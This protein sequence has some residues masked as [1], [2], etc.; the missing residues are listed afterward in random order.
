MRFTWT[1]AFPRPRQQSLRRTPRCRR[2]ALRTAH[3]RPFPL[4]LEPILSARVCVCVYSRLCFHAVWHM[5]SIRIT[6]LMWAAVINTLLFCS[7]STDGSSSLSVTAGLQSF[8]ATVY[9]YVFMNV[10]KARHFNR[11]DKCL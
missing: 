6:Q 4:Y 5:Y 8:Q 7:H 3:I 11:N 1:N 2:S 9:L 10:Y